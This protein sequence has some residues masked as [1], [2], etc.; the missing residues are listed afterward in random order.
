MRHNIRRP[1]YRLLSAGI[2]LVIA[3]SGGIGY[4]P[5]KPFVI[6]LISIVVLVSGVTLTAVYVKLRRNYL[7]VRSRQRR[8]IVSIGKTR[9]DCSQFAA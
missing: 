7:R 1:S 6:S 8:N 4:I 5:G 2:V 3:G 9:Q